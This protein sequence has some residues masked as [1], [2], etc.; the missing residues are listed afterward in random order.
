VAGANKL[1]GFTGTPGGSLSSVP[2]GCT[3]ANAIL[4]PALGV[5][6]SGVV[7]G[8]GE[9][10]SCGNSSFLYTPSN[11]STSFFNPPKSFAPSGYIFDG[12]SASSV[13]DSGTVVG[14]LL[15]TKGTSLVFDGYETA[16]ESTFSEIIDP[17]AVGDDTIPADINDSGDVVG[18]YI[19]SASN[20]IGFL[21][22]NG[23]YYDVNAANYTSAAVFTDATGIDAAG[24]IVG[25]YKDSSGLNYGFIL[26]GY[27]LAS[28]T[29]TGGTFTTLLDPSCVDGSTACNNGGNNE[30][31]QVL[32]ISQNG[33]EIVGKYVDSNNPGGVG[34][35]ANANVATP[36]PSAMLLMATGLLTLGF[37]WRKRTRRAV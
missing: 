1:F 6:G 7:A 34:F 3:P 33:D 20:S 13:N 10:T 30:G 32:G 9:G 37:Y 8:G 15:A 25:F 22:E 17:N 36:E 18:V 11:S 26:S 24:D 2:T 5:N 23:V 31:T 28:G 4:A 35:D 12:S 16:D 19:N 27:S 21:L 14:L 29:L